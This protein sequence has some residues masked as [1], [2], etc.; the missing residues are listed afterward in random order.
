MALV[1]IECELVDLS[2][3]FV[4]ACQL[5]TSSIKVIQDDLAIGSSGCN[6][7]AELA[8]RPFYVVDSQAISL[9]GRRAVLGIVDYSST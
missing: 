5:N 8:M 3:V 9:S 7:R 6:M 2:S 1:R 4:Q